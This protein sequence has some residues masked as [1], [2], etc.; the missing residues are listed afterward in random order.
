MA[1]AKEQI[2]EIKK[3]AAKFLYYK[4]PP[5]EI[6]NQVDLSYHIEEQSVYIFEIRPEWNALK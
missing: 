5:E 6:R 1:L 3:E 2:T 4:R